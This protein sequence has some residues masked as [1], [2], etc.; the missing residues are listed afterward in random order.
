MFLQLCSAVLAVSEAPAA[1]HAA[2]MPLQPSTS[3]AP[4]PAQHSA[5][6]VDARSDPDIKTQVPSVAVLCETVMPL[7]GDVLAISEAS[8]P[9]H[10]AKCRCGRQPV[11][12]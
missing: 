6:R 5:R 11:P 1:L 12:Q 8:A 9:L 10:A 7:C 3:H 2:K 4:C